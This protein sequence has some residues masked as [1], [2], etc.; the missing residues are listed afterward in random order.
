MKNII[1]FTIFSEYKQESF[2]LKTCLI[3]KTSVKDY[4]KFQK[5]YINIY[6]IYD[7]R[8]GLNKQFIWCKKKFRFSDFILFQSLLNKYKINASKAGVG[9][10]WLASKIWLF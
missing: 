10:L 6:C 5:V 2:L 7:L 4:I 1:F 8:V 9:N 3:N